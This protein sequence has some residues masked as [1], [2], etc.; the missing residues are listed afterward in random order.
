MQMK[1]KIDR[2]NIFGAQLKLYSYKCTMKTSNDANRN[3]ER[4]TWPTKASILHDAHGKSSIHR[5]SRTDY[6][7]IDAHCAHCI[8]ITHTHTS[9]STSYT[10]VNMCEWRRFGV[11]VCMWVGWD[12]MCLAVVGCI[13]LNAALVL[14]CTLDEHL[15]WT[16]DFGNELLE[17]KEDTNK[18]ES[19]G[20]HDILIQML[21]SL[22][23]LLQTFDSYI[24]R[25]RCI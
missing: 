9:T 11:C 3:V 15:S 25:M 17:K 2:N 7:A 10:S 8:H 4:S 20:A 23:T 22:F 19:Y 18:R 12:G 13:V 24:N 14:A 1:G 21:K 5:H 6:H 16:S